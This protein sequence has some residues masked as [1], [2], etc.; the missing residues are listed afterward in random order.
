MKKVM[1]RT[2]AVAGWCCLDWWCGSQDSLWKDRYRLCRSQRLNTMDWASCSVCAELCRLKLSW[3][4]TITVCSVL[5]CVVYMF[6]T[7]DTV[8]SAGLSSSKCN[9]TCS[10]GMKASV[11][12]RAHIGQENCFST[13]TDTQYITM[14]HRMMTRLIQSIARSF[15]THSTQHLNAAQEQLW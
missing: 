13:T 4:C 7:V 8:P 9:S 10:C 14:R 6:W 3:V 1:R 15:T 5:N 11:Q 12:T 2:W